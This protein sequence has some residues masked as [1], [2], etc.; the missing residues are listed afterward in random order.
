MASFFPTDQK[1]KSE[2]TKNRV[3]KYCLVGNFVPKTLR[4][5]TAFYIGQ[6]HGLPIH[7][8]FQFWSFQIRR[9]T[10]LNA[11]KFV[12][13]RVLGLLNCKRARRATDLYALN[14]W[15]IWSGW[16]ILLGIKFY[17]PKRYLKFLA[18]HL[19]KHKKIRYNLMNISTSLHMFFLE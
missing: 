14:L 17:R 4:F 2:I 15:N 13:P 8:F 7:N 3:D 5:V 10:F 12:Y 1:M 9:S 6:K 18:N 16:R 19:K 11:I